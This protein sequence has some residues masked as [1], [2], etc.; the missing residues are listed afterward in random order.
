[1]GRLSLLDNL[2]DEDYLVERLSLF[3]IGKSLG[4][5]CDHIGTGKAAASD[6]QRGHAHG[7]GIECL[8]LLDLFVQQHVMRG[9]GD[10]L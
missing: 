1:M 10:D 3:V 5:A 4:R 9:Q 8:T 6:L 2:Q 7:M